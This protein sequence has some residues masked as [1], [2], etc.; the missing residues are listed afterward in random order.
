M[1]TNDYKLFLKRY[2]EQVWQRGN[3]AALGK[4]VSTDCIYH[5]TALPYTL[6][7]PNALADYISH[8]RSA[9]RDWHFHA[10]DVIGEEETIAVRWIVQGV[11][12]GLLAHLP[13]SGRPVQLSGISLY[14]F[15]GS[16]I[17]EAWNCW[18]RLGLVKL[19]SVF[20]A[21]GARLIALDDAALAQAYRQHAD[22]AHQEDQYR[23]TDEQ[24]CAV[25]VG[26]AHE[27]SMQP[28]EPDLERE[29]GAV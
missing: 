9:L 24:I 8:V 16:K 14:R 15:Q 4:Y 2:V 17:I 7:G 23:V 20:C 28:Q 18:N 3:L 27:L 21:C 25:I 19:R 22:A 10:E 13:P 12:Q 6:N 5:D 1:K 29:Y 11:H 26:C